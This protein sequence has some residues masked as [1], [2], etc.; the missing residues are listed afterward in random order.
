MRNMSQIRSGSGASRRVALGVDPDIRSPRPR[1]AGTKGGCVNYKT[2][3]VCPKERSTRRRSYI[4][5]RIRFAST[6]RRTVLPKHHVRARSSRHVMSTACECHAEP[7]GT[8]AFPRYDVHAD[9]DG[10]V[11]MF[12]VTRTWTQPAMVPVRIPLRPIP[13]SAIDPT[14]CPQ[15]PFRH[16]RSGAYSL[17]CG[18]WKGSPQRIRFRFTSGGRYCTIC[19]RHSV[20]LIRC[21]PTSLCECNF[22]GLSDPLIAPG[23][24]PTGIFPNRVQI[25][26]ERRGARG[27]PS[28]ILKNPHWRL[29]LFFT[30]EH[31]A[32]FESYDVRVGGS[33]RSGQ[34]VVDSNSNATMLVFVS[35]S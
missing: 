12:R 18:T 16:E 22:W 29:Q 35:C 4:G 24:L 34:R 1:S 9:I 32:A 13:S 20:D 7:V 30:L 10:Q 3:T 6:L 23:K 11:I 15:I 17:M 33:F 14:S 25:R 5:K 2:T 28:L 26:R 31:C 27:L 19:F 21:D 8:Y